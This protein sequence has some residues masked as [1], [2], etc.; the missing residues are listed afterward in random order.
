[1]FGV[2]NCTIGSFT[3]YEFSNVNGSSLN[4]SKNISIF[5]G[6]PE[7]L[8]LQVEN[9]KFV[10]GNGMPEVIFFFYKRLVIKLKTLTGR[11]K[12]EENIAVIR[13]EES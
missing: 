11:S 12:I 2:I 13:V 1:M 10:D 9:N 8:M 6:I 5:K 3:H 7:I 4:N